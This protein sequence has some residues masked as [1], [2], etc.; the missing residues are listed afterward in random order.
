[1]DFMLPVAIAVSLIASYLIG[2]INGAIIVSSVRYKDDIRMQGSGNAGFTNFKRVHGMGSSTVAV[3]LIDIL[4]TV[5]PVLC[6]A[7]IFEEM[8]GFWSMGAAVAALGC[9]IGHCYP[10]WYNFR[11]GKGM[12][13][14]FT[15]IWFIDYRMA[16]VVAVVFVLALLIF[17]FMSFASC[18]GTIMCPIATAVIGFDSWVTLAATILMA[19]IVVFRHRSNIRRL[20]NGTESKFF[21]NK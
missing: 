4:K 12:L 19:A 11:G 15:A 20:L 16:I 18:F 9:V 1:M 14:L 10:V 7:I 6:S 17:K 3:L 13:A 21:G 5:V 2:G 8:F